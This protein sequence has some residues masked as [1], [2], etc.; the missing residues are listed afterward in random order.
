MKTIEILRNAATNSSFSNSTRSFLQLLSQQGYAHTGYYQGSGRHTKAIDKTNEVV[1]ALR[2]LRIAHAQGNDAPRGGVSGNFVIITSEAVM[3]EIGK[4]DEY[5]KLNKIAGSE[6]KYV[7]QTPYTHEEL[8]SRAMKE[9][10]F[11]NKEDENDVEGRYW[12]NAY[13]GCGTYELVIKNGR[14]AAS[15]YCGFH[16]TIPQGKNRISPTREEWIAA[17]AEVV[18]SRIG[19][20]WQWVKA[21]GSGT[22]FFL[23]NMEDAELLDEVKWYDVPDMMNGGLHRNIEIR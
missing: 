7:K 3:K 22:Y 23:R 2:S 10:S 15:L 13:H 17:L 21:D 16:P 6:W 5:K 9:L 8:I 20:G 18:T 14:I 12:L 4:S 1:S 19:E 11:V